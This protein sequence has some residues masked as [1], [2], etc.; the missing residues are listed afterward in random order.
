MGTLY[1][2]TTAAQAL[3]ELLQTEEI[4]EQTLN[5][6]LTAMGA[7]EKM[8]SYCKVIKQLSADIEMF[9]TEQDRLSS[10][11]KTLENSVD[12][13]KGALLDFMQ[14]CGQKKAEAGTFKI[15][16]SPSQSV[17]I[18]DEE[19]SPALY[20]IPCPDKIDKSGIKKAL[21]EG[22]EIAGAELVTNKG[23]RIR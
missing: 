23:V 6:T 14:A 21:K 15:S 18:T 19:K 20:R 2:L 9:K 16:I 7:D 4:D 17:N 8:E 11:K 3:Y 1:E 5:D 13:M 10:R 22:V 12:R